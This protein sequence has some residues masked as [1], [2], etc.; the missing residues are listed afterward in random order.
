MGELKTTRELTEERNERV[1]NMRE[2]KLHEF[3]QYGTWKYKYKILRV[4]GGWI[5][6]VRYLWKVDSMFISEG[7][8]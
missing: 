8:K 6:T 2:M 1:S 7:R 3:R 5:Y 4:P